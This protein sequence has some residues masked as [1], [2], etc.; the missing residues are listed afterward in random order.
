MSQELSH[1]P[2]FRK[3]GREGSQ[4]APEM[5]GSEEKGRRHGLNLWVGRGRGA[6]R[7]DPPGPP[8]KAR[9]LPKATRGAGRVGTGVTGVHPVGP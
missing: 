9:A 8:L 5:K 6:R 4:H 7:A 3:G 1:H 2:Q